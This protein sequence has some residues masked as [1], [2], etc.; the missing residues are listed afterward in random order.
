[1]LN[2]TEFISAYLPFV[3]L[4][5]WPGAVDHFGLYQKQLCQIQGW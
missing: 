1:M 3:P 5:Q 4:D 2:H